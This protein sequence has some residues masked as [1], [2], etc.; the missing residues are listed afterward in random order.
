MGGLPYAMEKNIMI[1]LTGASGG[2]GR[3]LIP[4]LIEIEEVIGIY[5]TSLPDITADKRV[6]YEKVNLENMSDIVSFAKKQGQDASKITVIHA[7]VY[8][9]DDLVVN[10]KPDDWDH[11]IRVNL[12]ANFLLT[13]ALLPY[14]IRHKW[15]RIIHFSSLGGIQGR[16]GTIAYSTSKAG[17][18]GMSNVLAKEYACFNITSNVLILGHFET[19]LFHKLQE[20]EKKRLLNSIPS[21]TLGKVSNI[22]NAIRF[23]I[24]SDYITGATINI[25][26]GAQ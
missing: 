23:L 18:I 5:N 2:I 24:M 1:I 10:Y 3:E 16:P 26:G 13:Q 17:L 7:A 25:D 14:M 11:S 8:K 15:G 6:R 21:K 19:G 12:K 20:E 9:K 22:A 4:H